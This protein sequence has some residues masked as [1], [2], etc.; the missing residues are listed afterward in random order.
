MHCRRGI[1]PPTSPGCT[2]WVT[3]G[4]VEA[5]ESCGMR[6]RAVPPPHIRGGLGAKTGKDGL[7]AC[8]LLERDQ[9]QTV[10]L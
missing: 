7:G 8:T 2:P 3:I 9:S 6:R 10:C 5:T 1:Y 4:I